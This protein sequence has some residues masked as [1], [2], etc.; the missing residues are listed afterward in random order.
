MAMNNDE[1]S[2][3]IFLDLANAFD[4]VNHIILLNKLERYGVRRIALNW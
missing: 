4:T 3:G 2:T 1:Y